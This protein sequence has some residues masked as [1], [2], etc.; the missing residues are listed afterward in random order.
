MLEA[1]FVFLKRQ[2][3]GGVLNEKQRS[4]L[5]N[6]IKS[7]YQLQAALRSSQDELEDINNRLELSRAQ[8]C[9]VKVKDICYPGVTVTIREYKYIVRE[10]FRNVAFVFDK[11]AREIKMRPFDEVG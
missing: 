1:D 10:A 7:K 3:Q 9:V 8:E 5:I 4:S 2:E 11:E 6:V